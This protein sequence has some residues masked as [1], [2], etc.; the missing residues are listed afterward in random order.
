LK[1]SVWPPSF[2]QPLQNVSAESSLI[3][4]SK[5]SLFDS[6]AIFERSRMTIAPAKSTPSMSTPARG[7]LMKGANFDVPALFS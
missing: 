5:Q 1:D 6:H 7:T 4:I 3:K 2:L